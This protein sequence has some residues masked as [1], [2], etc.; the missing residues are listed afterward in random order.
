MTSAIVIEMADAALADA[1]IRDA[2]M[3]LQ[4]EIERVF[5]FE[6]RV[7]LGH[8]HVAAEGTTTVANDE[9]G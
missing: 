8:T 9:A 7:A 6:V 1:S 4:I 3:D 2:T 5:V